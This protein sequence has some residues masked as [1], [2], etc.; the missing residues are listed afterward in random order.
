MVIGVH[1][2]PLEPT[3]AS[4][5]Y[6]SMQRIEHFLR[7]D[8]VPD[9]ASSLSAVPV[10]PSNDIGFSSATFRWESDGLSDGLGKFQL[11]PLDVLFSKGR[12]NLVSGPTG[13]GKSALLAALLGEM[14]C[15]SGSVHLNKMHNSV[16]YC[17]QNPCERL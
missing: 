1:I 7:E 3:D 8:E 15:V 13:S 11:G 10:A 4:E 9:W 5:A 2:R 6:V 16:A 12:I 17:A 14:Q